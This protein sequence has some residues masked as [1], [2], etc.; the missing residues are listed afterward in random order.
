VLH[1]A[2]LAFDVWSR[3]NATFDATHE[4]VDRVIPGALTNEPEPHFILVTGDDAAELLASHSGID[5][6]ITPEIPEWS[7]DPF[8]ASQKFA[9]GSGLLRQQGARLVLERTWF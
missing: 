4:T 9:A 3:T 2:N 5:Q 8:T 6:L 1:D 7:R